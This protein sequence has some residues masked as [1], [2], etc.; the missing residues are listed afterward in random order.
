ML[1]LKAAS[2]IFLLNPEK[3]DCWF[4]LPDSKKDCWKGLGQ[5]TMVRDKKK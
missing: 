4:S 1:T 2:I 5:K 3:N